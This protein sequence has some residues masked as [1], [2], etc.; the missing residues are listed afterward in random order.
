MKLTEH[1]TLEEL[2]ASDIAQRNGL[3]N[4][5]NDIIVGNLNRLAR[6]LEEVRLLLNK[7]IRV[8]SGYRALAVNALLGSKP[9]SQHCIGCAA[10]IKVDGM[11][12]DEVVKAIVNS[13]IKYDQVIREFDSWV[14][15]SVPNGE[16]YVPR[17]QALIIDKTGTRPYA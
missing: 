8:N 17:K 10:D 6:L 5:P 16:G 1:F 11:K 9:T 13:N 7:S 3:D 15:I 2:I 12:P 4:N 14:H